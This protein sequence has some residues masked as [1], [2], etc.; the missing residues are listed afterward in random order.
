MNSV[1]VCVGHVT[2]TC[3]RRQKGRQ[4]GRQWTQ[5]KK[6]EGNGKAESNGICGV[7]LP[8]PNLCEGIEYSSISPFHL[9]SVT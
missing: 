7:I 8:L 5:G 6:Q 9:F 3:P 2:I 4:K 1:E